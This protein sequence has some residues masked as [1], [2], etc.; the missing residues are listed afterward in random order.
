M[1]PRESEQQSTNQEIRIAEG[2]LRPDIRRSHSL[3]LGVSP[4]GWQDDEAQPLKQN[5]ALRKGSEKT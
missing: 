5:N 2:F 1:S 4:D 3:R